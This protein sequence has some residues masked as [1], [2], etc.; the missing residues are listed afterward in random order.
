MDIASVALELYT[1][2]DETKRDFAGTIRKVAA[3]G[4]KGVEFAGYGGLTAQ[5]M[6]ALL[7]ETGLR[8]VSTHIGLQALEQDIAKEIAYCQEIGCT[9][10]VLPSLAPELRRA[11]AFRQL[12]PRLN[13]FGRQCREAGITFGYHN[14][15]FE[16]EQY[17]GETLMDTLLTTTD[18]ALVKLELDVY[19]AAYAGVNPSALLQKHV[20]RIPLVHLKDMTPQ[21]TFTEVGDGTLSIQSIV[22]VALASGTQEFIVEN[23]APTLPSLESARR[24]LENIRT[25]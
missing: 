13:A 2:R 7:S 17:E 25:F 8:A 16:F 1:V 23:D 21:R 11:A 12:A 5:E 4:Y 10:L 19:W 22:Q 20:G 24:S 3:L 14:H 6:K 18:A 15:D 9:F